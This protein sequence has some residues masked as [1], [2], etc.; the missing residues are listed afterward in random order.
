MSSAGP[1]VRQ[2]AAH[3]LSVAAWPLPELRKP[4]FTAVLHCGIVDRSRLRRTLLAGSRREHPRL[5][6]AARVGYRAGQISPRIL[7]RLRVS[8]DSVFLS[9]GRI[10]D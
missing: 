7:V 8:R 3:Q 10:R 4:L 1:L 9:V 2:F 5:A 6:A